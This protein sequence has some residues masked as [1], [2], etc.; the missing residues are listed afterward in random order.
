MGGVIVH[1]GMIFPDGFEC[2]CGINHTTT[3]GAEAARVG[4]RHCEVNTPSSLLDTRK[5]SFD[6]KII[7]FD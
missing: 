6:Q 4:F 2:S 5:D 1:H 3:T 7:T